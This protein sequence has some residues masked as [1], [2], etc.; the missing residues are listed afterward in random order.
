MRFNCMAC[1]GTARLLIVSILYSRCSDA[2]RRAEG[3]RRGFQFSIRDATVAAQWAL[4]PTAGYSFNSLFEMR[5]QHG[6]FCRP[7]EKRIGFNSLFEMQDTP[8]C[9]CTA[10]AWEKGF[11][12]LFEMPRDSGCKTAAWTNPVSILYSRCCRQKTETQ[13]LQS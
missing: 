10:T 8:S 1:P 11:N 5:L 3:R 2:P 7:P 12:S 4:D 6:R 9:N 13:T